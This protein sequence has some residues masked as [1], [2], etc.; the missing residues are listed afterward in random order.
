MDHQTLIEKTIGE[1]IRIIHE[2]DYGPGDRIPNEYEL[3][4]ALGVSRNTAR[5]AL[6]ALAARNV[7]EIRQGA[8]T[9]VSKKMGVSNDPLGFD[10]I[11]DK[12]KLTRD[13]LQLRCIIEPPIAALAAQNAT[14]PSLAELEIALLET[15]G[16]IAQH[17]RFAEKD[18]QF[19]AQIARCSGNLVVS[20][21]IPII[22]EGVI[23]FANVV[24]QQEY[25]QTLKSHRNIFEAIRNREPVEAEQAM[26]FHLLY[27]MNR[28]RTGN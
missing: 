14:P 9:F 20:N 16:Q 8:G 19:H 26:R 6:R 7:I 18:Q 13:L 17:E 1:I 24:N 11:S 4:E 28:L 25:K 3:C 21:L 23:V 22:S 10:L 27:N 15:E 12:N 5:E 2:K